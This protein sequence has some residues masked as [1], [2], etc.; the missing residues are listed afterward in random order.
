MGLD[1]LNIII[2]IKYKYN[3]IQNCTYALL[4]LGIMIYTTKYVFFAQ[5]VRI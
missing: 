5:Y 1:F 4:N 3:I 2:Y